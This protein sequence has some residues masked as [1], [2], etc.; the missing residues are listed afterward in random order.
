MDDFGGTP[1][2]TGVV[3][4]H[5]GIHFDR[6]KKCFVSQSQRFP[7]EMWHFETSGEEGQP[8]S[9]ISLGIVAL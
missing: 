6:P 8:K 7:K 3:K 5:R 1:P 2:G 9:E 4:Y